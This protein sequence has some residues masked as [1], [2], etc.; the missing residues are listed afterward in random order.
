MRR[1]Q[2]LDMIIPLQPRPVEFG[3]DRGAFLER[4]I[5]DAFGDKESVRE[6]PRRVGHDLVDPAAVSEELAAFYVGESRLRRVV[7]PTR[8]VREDAHHEVYRGEGE[9]GLA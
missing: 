9:L 8:V 7:L 5:V 6:R 4:D 3:V 2:F 1:T